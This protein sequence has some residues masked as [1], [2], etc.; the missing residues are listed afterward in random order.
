M[1][2]V[3]SAVIEKEAQSAPLCQ[4]GRDIRYLRL[5]YLSIYAS[6]PR[7][8][9]SRQ[10]REGLAGLEKQL[11]HLHQVFHGA[12]GLDLTL[13]ESGHAVNLFIHDPG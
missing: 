6:P 12:F 11:L 9:H 8:S 5:N 3:V 7:G 1:D 4:Y 10:G 13:H 2:P